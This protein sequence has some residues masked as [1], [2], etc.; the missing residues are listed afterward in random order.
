MVGNWYIKAKKRNLKNSNHDK[1]ELV[2][3]DW[4]QGIVDGRKL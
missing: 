3:I 4:K 2:R 1:N